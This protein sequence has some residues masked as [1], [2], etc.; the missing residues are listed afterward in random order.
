MLDGRNAFLAHRIGM[1]PLRRGTLRAQQNP[2]TVAAHKVAV[3]NFPMYSSAHM[4]SCPRVY[5]LG[6]LLGWLLWGNLAIAQSAASFVELRSGNLPVILSAPHGGYET[7]SR[8]PDRQCAT[9]VTVRDTRTLEL[10]REIWRQVGLLTGQYPSGVFSLLSRVK[11][12]PN[13]AIVEAAQ[14]DPLAEAVWQVYH[15][16]IKTRQAEARQTY[17]R[18]L[19]LDIHG[20]GHAAQRVEVGYGLSGAQLRTHAP[21]ATSVVP[22]NSV[23]GLAQASGTST[24][25]LLWGDTAFG[26][27]LARGGLPATPSAEDPYPLSGELYF[28]GGY[29]TLTYAEAAWADAV[30]LEFNYEGVRD[31]E[32]SIRRTAKIVATAVVSYLNTHYPAFVDRPLVRPSLQGDVFPNPAHD[33]LFYHRATTIHP[34][35]QVSLHD[36]W[37]RRVWLGHEGDLAGGLSLRPFAA[38]VYVLTFHYVDRTEHVRIVVV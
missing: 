4:R 29:I 5:G 22:G 8:I 36:V 38:G 37:G 9:C 10:A 34:S 24:R 18:V 14:G 25:L 31:G 30:Q 23:S 27:M 21:P 26:T 20:H 19:T 11:L 15:E 13:R 33:R 16:S 3:T 35:E 6:W 28:S 12:D 17:G 32:A 1:P 2:P 7:P